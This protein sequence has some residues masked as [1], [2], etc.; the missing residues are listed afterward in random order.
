[1]DIMDMVIAEYMV[2]H[3]RAKVRL[4]DVFEPG[5][6]GRGLCYVRY[7]ESESP[8]NTWSSLVLNIT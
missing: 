5:V 4:V 6:L 2:K 3:P 1:M 7:R 8:G